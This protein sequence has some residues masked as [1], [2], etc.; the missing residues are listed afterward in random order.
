M[1]V[2]YIEYLSKTILLINILLINKIQTF[3]FDNMLIINLDGKNVIICDLNKRLIYKEY[4]LDKNKISNNRYND[5]YSYNQKCFIN[6]CILLS[7]GNLL[8]AFGNGEI[9]IVNFLVPVNFS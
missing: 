9:E 1:M 6:N 3:N 8:I 4:S 2:K 7:N 5:Y